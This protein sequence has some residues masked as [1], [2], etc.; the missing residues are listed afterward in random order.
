ME[1]PKL[2]LNVV[3][4]PDKVSEF[5]DWMQQP[6]EFIAADT[7]TTGLDVFAPGF[8][9]RLLQFGDTHSG[10][11]IPFQGWKEL[12]RW[13][14][15]WPANAGIRTVWHNAAYDMSALH[16]EG[17]DVDAAFTDDTFVWASLCGYAEESRALKSIASRE[18]GT[19]AQFGQQ[20]LKTAMANAGWDWE[21]VPLDFGPYVAYGTI[22]PIITA[23][24]YERLGKARE[25]FRWQHSLEIHAIETTNR[26]ARNGVGVDTAYAAAQ[27]E[28]LQAEEAEILAQLAPHGITSIGQNAAVAKALQAG[29]IP[30]DVFKQTETGALAVDKKFLAAVDHPIAK[31]VLQGRAKHK[32]ASYFN[33]M[34]SA[35]R[36]N[37]SDREIIHPEIR[38][39]EARTSRTSVSAPALQQ[40]PSV[41][42]KDPDSFRVRKAIIPRMPDEVLVGADYGQ[43]ELRM[44]AGLSKDEALLGVLN[45]MDAEKAAGNKNADFFVNLGRDLYHEPDFQKSDHRRT[46]LKSTIYALMFSA[47]EETIAATANVPQKEIHQTIEELTAKYHS[48]ATLRNDAIRQQGQSW[49]ITTWTGREFRVRKRT[50]I[51]KLCNYSIQGGAAE[52]LKMAMANVEEAGWGENLM[53]PV[54]DELIMSVPR[55]DAEKA[56]RD[57]TEAMDAVIDPEM[58][59]VAIR[60]SAADPAENWAAL[61]H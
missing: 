6:R 1:I 49:H 25:K 46:K 27:I 50:D 10:W 51:R 43:I 3:D 7:E 37:I 32:V 23:M 47:G 9:V 18:F 39:M 53:L 21:T 38:S 4:N 11:A 60:A 28:E 2:D 20:L 36:G 13:A 33:A 42:E 16:A 52:V 55:N 31:L 48:F 34:L 54:H 17:I 40:L 61:S 30:A 8:K 56:T 15:T 29:G 45:A 12:A 19:W 22:D 58:L 41:D 35:A 44:F 24:Y 26:M 57:L 59:G 14:L 5:M